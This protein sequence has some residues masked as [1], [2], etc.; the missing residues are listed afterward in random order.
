MSTSFYEEATLFL[1]IESSLYSW[2]TQKTAPE[3]TEVLGSL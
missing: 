2:S 3:S 1:E